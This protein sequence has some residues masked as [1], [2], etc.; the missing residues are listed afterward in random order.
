V[1]AN[2]FDEVHDKLNEEAK[3]PTLHGRGCRPQPRCGTA[4]SWTGEGGSKATEPALSV[5]PL[6]AVH[7]TNA[8]HR[9][10]GDPHMR[11][12]RPFGYSRHITTSWSNEE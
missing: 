9:T 5:L 7:N 4:G 1:L 3:H 2:D 10:S 12:P 11:R 8:P 6:R